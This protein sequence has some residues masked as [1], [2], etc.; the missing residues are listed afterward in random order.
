LPRPSAQ[1]LLTLLQDLLQTQPSA[2]HVSPAD[3]VD[4]SFLDELEQTGLIEAIYG[5]TAE[6]GG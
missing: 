4:S 3:F 5:D 6:A 1:G 2:V